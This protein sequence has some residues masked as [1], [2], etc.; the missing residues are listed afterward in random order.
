MSKSYA[1]QTASTGVAAASEGTETAGSLENQIQLQR[2]KDQ[3]AKK[4]T[5]INMLR[6]ESTWMKRELRERDE[7][8]KALKA[9]VKTTP[10]KKAEAYRSR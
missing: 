2:A 9:T 7:E 10:K 3:L 4:D 8:I 1:M 5:E 6:K